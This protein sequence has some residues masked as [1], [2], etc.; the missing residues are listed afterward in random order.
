MLLHLDRKDYPNINIK[1]KSN[2]PEMLK[3]N[4]KWE[5]IAVR[6]GSAIITASGLDDKRTH[7]KILAISNKG[8][9]SNFT[10]N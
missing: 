3:V 10:L 7:I 1:F 4:N 2:H 8:F 9:I 5:I 6:P